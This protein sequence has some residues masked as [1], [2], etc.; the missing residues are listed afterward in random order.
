MSTWWLTGSDRLGVPRFKWCLDPP[1]AVDPRPVGYTGQ[2][3][4]S[5]PS[6]DEA[7]ELV[8]DRYTLPEGLSYEQTTF[9]ASQR[10]VYRCVV[11][12]YSRALGY[13]SGIEVDAPTCAELERESLAHGLPL[14]WG[15][16]ATLPLHD[17]VVH[18][19]L[20]LRASRSD[21]DFLLTTFS[22]DI[23]W[24]QVQSRGFQW[25]RSGYIEKWVLTGYGG[26][27]TL[28]FLWYLDD[29]VARDLT[30]P[31]YSKGEGYFELS[32]EKARRYVPLRYTLPERLRY[33][34]RPVSTQRGIYRCRVEVYSNELTYVASFAVD[35][36]TCIELEQQSLA[37]GR[38][39]QWGYAGRHPLNA[40]VVEKVLGLRA[41]RGDLSF[42]LISYSLHARR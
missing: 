5:F 16:A 4:R 18:R 22:L 30:S 19:V 28:G 20:G 8:S 10:G 33:Q 12:V 27:R 2:F 34:L 17:D 41:C 21:V 29:D 23:P 6:Q 37:M 40:A 38:P 13:L 24:D 31:D 26:A 36:P 9:G 7:R 35:V 42:R 15:Y 11:N 32:R 1:P 39:L 3:Y 14:Q 25:T